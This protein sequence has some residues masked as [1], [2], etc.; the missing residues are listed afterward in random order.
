MKTVDRVLNWALSR[1]FQ[2]RYRID[3]GD[4]CVRIVQIEGHMTAADVAIMHGILG[5]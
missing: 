3:D 1:A 4:N 5:K 2:S